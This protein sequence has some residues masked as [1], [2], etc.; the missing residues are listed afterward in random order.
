MFKYINIGLL[1]IILSLK[2]CASF[3]KVEFTDPADAYRDT[4]REVGIPALKYN[5]GD[6]MEGPV[7]WTGSNAGEE[8][9][10]V[11]KDGYVIK[12]KNVGPKYT[13]FGQGLPGLDFSQNLAIKVNCVSEGEELPLL[14]LQLDDVNGY[15]TNAKRPTNRIANDGKFRDYYF[16]LKG[17]WVQSWPSAH[18]VDG[19][20]INKIMFFVNPGGS[21]YNGTLKIKEIKVISADSIKETEKIKTP[22]GVPGAVIDDFSGDLSAWWATEGKFFKLSKTES[23]QLKVDIDGAGPGYECIGR[24]F[25]SIDFGK[26]YK[27]KAKIRLEGV[28]DAPE[29]RID[30]KDMDGYTCNAKPATNR[31]L[32]NPDGTMK[33]F[34]FS[35][36]GRF[37]QTYPDMHEVDPQ[38]INNMVIFFNPGKAP[39]KGTIYID[40][41]E[42]VNQGE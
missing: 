4:T 38:R 9:S 29:I 27:L 26:A 8:L 24:G 39:F 40:D 19:A 13:P 32:P 5:N 35:Y 37:L 21:A 30:I 42:A 22:P 36:K 6:L 16:P 14:S 2:D 31:I 1:G 12:F 25:K 17:S 7:W 10:L 34:T 15:Q 18:N 11:Q 33:E 3:E 20:A 41:I 23:G 28:G